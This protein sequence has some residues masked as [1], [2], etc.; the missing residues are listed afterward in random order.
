MAGKIRV[1]PSSDAELSE[2]FAAPCANPSRAT[3]ARKETDL[4]AERASSP[5]APC[6]LDH[7]QLRSHMHIFRTI[8][9][10]LMPFP[11]RPSHVH[12]LLCGV[13]DSLS[14]RI[15]AGCRWCDRRRSSGATRY[16]RGRNERRGNTAAQGGNETQS[17]GAGGQHDLTGGAIFVDN[18]STAPAQYPNRTFTFNPLTP[19]QI[20]YLRES[21]TRDML[22]LTGNP[23]A[24][25]DDD[26]SL[27]SLESVY[28]D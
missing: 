25:F 19:E 8:R 12:S 13:C 22:K 28:N 21:A 18:Q 16:Q 2:P 1:L 14:V 5:L 6:R 17:A 3:S 7:Q 9:K 4:D 20:A 11:P 26:E 23:Q 10:H 15:C 24:P 27:P